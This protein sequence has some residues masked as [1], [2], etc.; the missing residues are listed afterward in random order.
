MFSDDYIIRMIRQ[1]TAVLAKI[2]G[3]KQAGEYTQALQEIDQALEQ[4]LGM[5][6]DIIRILDDEGVYRILTQNGKMDLEKLEFIADLF[7]EEGEILLLQ[8]QKQQSDNYFLSSLTY[9]LK[10][11]LNADASQQEELSRKLEAVVRKLGDHP[12][13]DGILFDLS[14]HYE[15]N[16]KYAKAESILTMP[17]ARPGMGANGNSELVAF[18]QRLLELDPKVLSAN[19]M[20]RKK[21]QNKLKELS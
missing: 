8:G 4:S 17:S 5:D 15:N 3:L 20:S 14:C 12:Y 7:K 11:S 18:Y 9:Y 21:I 2:I 10:V 13:P 16:G 1:A 19:G 6:I